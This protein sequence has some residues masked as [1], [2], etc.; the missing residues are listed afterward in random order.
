MLLALLTSA[1]AGAIPA[2]HWPPGEVQRFHIETELITPRGVRYNA[3]ENNDALAGIVKIRADAGCVAKPEG[4]TNIVTCTFAYIDMKAQ[5]LMPDEAP[6]LDKIMVEWTG[7]LAGTSVE[8]ELG[9]DGRLKYFDAKAKKVQSTH[10]EGYNLE[11][12][13]ILLQ[14]VFSPFDL[15]LTTDEKDWT[16]GWLQKTPSALMVL[17][18][19]SGTVG[20]VE[21]KHKHIDDQDGM[22]VIE[23]TARATL[24]AGAAVDA[25]SGGRQIDV[26]MAGQTIFDTTRGMMM[27]R[28]F[29]IDGRLTVSSQLAG[30]S[31]EYSQVGA[32]QWV[33]EFPAPGEIPPSLTAM[34]APK[35]DGKAPDAVGEQVLFST[36]GMNPLYVEGHPEGARSLQLGKTKVKARVVIG[37]DGVPRSVK[38]FEGF[39][40]LGP[41]TEAALSAARFP[42]RAEPYTVDVEVEWRPT[43]AQ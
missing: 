27:W 40:A 20:A 5:A 9:M 42:V 26:K 37:A 24:S 28:D 31:R 22:P 14:R 2:W 29:S 32:I 7:D 12:Q 21:M 33:P 3:A 34:R 39:T 4:K 41:A 43:D 25:G 10:R 38:A 11:Q 1:H 18:T 19:I 13:R 6:E 16:R 35:L 17:Q 30:D 36:L 8:L 15:P 23:T